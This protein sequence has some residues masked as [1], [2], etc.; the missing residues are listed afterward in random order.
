MPSSI[1]KYL[2]KNN[3]ASAKEDQVAVVVVL[4]QQVR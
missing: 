2:K 1:Q 4:P 3:D